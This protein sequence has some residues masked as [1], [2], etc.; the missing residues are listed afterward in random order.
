MSWIE[1]NIAILVGWLLTTFALMYNAGKFK[2]LVEKRIE[3][4]ETEM[5][6]QKEIVRALERI[7][8]TLEVVVD[9][10]EKFMDKHSG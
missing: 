9:R 4:L 6:D 2:S 8:I 1:N 7:V 10:L 3:T 5:K